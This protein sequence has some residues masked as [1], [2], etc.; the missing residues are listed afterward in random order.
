[1]GS[2]PE[3]IQPP[4]ITSPRFARS[5]VSGRGKPITN[6]TSLG[7]PPFGIGKTSIGEKLRAIQIAHAAKD[8]RMSLPPDFTNITQPA[9]KN[10]KLTNRK[11]GNQKRYEASR[12]NNPRILASLVTL[13]GTFIED[14]LAVGVFEIQDWLAKHP[15]YAN[16]RPG[17]SQLV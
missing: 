11:A 14:D 6:G 7:G 3:T 17:D 12:K 13:R 1:L 10:G 9:I 8:R 4:N 5:T 15:H 2:N 16:N